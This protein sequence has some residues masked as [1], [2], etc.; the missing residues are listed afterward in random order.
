MI[1]VGVSSKTTASLWR[2]PQCQFLFY[3]PDLVNGALN[4]FLVNRTP[5]STPKSEERG[6]YS[7][8]RRARSKE[9]KNALISHNKL[10]P[11]WQPKAIA[12]LI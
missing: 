5:T 2:L 1:N 9:N 4:K 11:E 12:F 7:G 3:V 6:R 10:V 8:R